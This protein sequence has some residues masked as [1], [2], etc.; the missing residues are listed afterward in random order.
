[1]KHTLFA[2]FED[3]YSA[4]V[5]I[6]ELERLG[7]EKGHIQRVFPR[8]DNGQVELDHTGYL[9]STV[10]VSASFA[11]LF[12]FA[13][14]ALSAIGVLPLLTIGGFALGAVLGLG[15]GA[16][17][18]LLAGVVGPDPRLKKLIEKVGDN[19]V[20]LAIKVEG[21]A[22]RDEVSRFLNTSHHGHTRTV[23]V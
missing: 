1:M 14:A 2:A 6:G 9:R 23:P 13:F 19:A 18:G 16:V 7:V 3:K 4:E 5:A 12:G 17:S 8:L 11:L 10:V 22:K 21:L 15:L 20:I